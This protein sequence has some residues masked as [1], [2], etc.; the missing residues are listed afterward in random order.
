M[1]AEDPLSRKRRRTWADAG[2]AQMRMAVTKQETLSMFLGGL[3]RLR[4]GAKGMQNRREKNNGAEDGTA[5]WRKDEKSL[6]LREIGVFV[7]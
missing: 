2:N 6:Y 4:E 1:G 7:F 5:V 3:I